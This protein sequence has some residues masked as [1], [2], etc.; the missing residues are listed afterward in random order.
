MIMPGTQW[1]DT[2]RNQYIYNSEQVENVYKDLIG[3]WEI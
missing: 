1:P 2:N 3:E